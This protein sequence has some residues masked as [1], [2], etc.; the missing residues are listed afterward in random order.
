MTSFL[1]LFENGGLISFWVKSSWRHFNQANLESAKYAT[2]KIVDPLSKAE[3]LRRIA[4][5][6]FDHSDPGP[7]YDALDESIKLIS[8]VEGGDRRI[9]SLINLLPTVQRIDRNRLSDLSELTAKSINSIPSL[10]VEDKPQTKNFKNYVTSMMN[11]NWNLL[12]ALTKLLKENK[13]DA[14]NLAGR[15]D[16]KE[17]RIIADYVLL[18]DLMVSRSTNLESKIGIPD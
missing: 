15:I 9:F 7:T 13:S 8:R 11:I 12:P 2:K 18:T 10:D 1:N 3:S 4:N 5:Y 14:A 6:Y 16:K 17:I